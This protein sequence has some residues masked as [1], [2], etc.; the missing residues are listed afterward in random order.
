MCPFPPI[1]N[2]S[3]N[4][5]HWLFSWKRNGS[6]TNV[7]G[8]SVTMP[9]VII[10][11]ETTEFGCRLVNGPVVTLC[12]SGLVVTGPLVGTTVGVNTGV[13]VAVGAVV[14]VAEGNG[15]GPLAP[16]DWKLSK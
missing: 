12:Q 7:L 5:Y 9:A 6:A 11:L 15:C 1:S 16:Q 4:R 13:G 8:I 10:G 2:T 14:G 3:K